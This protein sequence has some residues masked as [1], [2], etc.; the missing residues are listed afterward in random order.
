MKGFDIK[1]E[2]Q[3]FDTFAEFANEAERYL[4]SRSS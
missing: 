4:I 2:I 1:T 3:E